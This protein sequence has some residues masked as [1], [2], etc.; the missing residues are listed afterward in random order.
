[1][2]WCLHAHLESPAGMKDFLDK[3]YTDIQIN[4]NGRND[5]QKKE[6]EFRKQ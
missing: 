4:T 5:A 2:V 1:M 6:R 3:N